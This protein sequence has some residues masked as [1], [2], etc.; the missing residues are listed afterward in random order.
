MEFVKTVFT[1]APRL[2]AD[3]SLPPP[4]AARS[5]A[6]CVFHSLP[7]AFKLSPPKPISV[8]MGKSTLARL[9]GVLAANGSYSATSSYDPLW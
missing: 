1:G 9:G 2:P 4:A 7:T 8:S 6:F 3:S 5:R